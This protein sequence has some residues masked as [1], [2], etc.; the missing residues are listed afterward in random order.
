[1]TGEDTGI[2]ISNYLI[3]TTPGTS[4]RILTTATPSSC[5]STTRMGHTASSCPPPTLSRY[6]VFS[7]SLREDFRCLILWNDD[8]AGWKTVGDCFCDNG[9]E[10]R[11]TS[12]Q[13]N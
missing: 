3:V 12:K 1:M 11:V 8:I 6:S 9:K 7:V 10:I 4:L 2:M 5:L 13:S